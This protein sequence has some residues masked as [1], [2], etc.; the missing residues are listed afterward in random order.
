MLAILWQILEYS[1]SHD[2]ESGISSI[3]NNTWLNKNSLT[4][5]PKLDGTVCNV[6]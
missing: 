5:E 6:K 2:N 1:M 4:L 3:P